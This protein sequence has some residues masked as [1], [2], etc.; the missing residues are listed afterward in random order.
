MIHQYI[1]QEVI[2]L[3]YDKIKGL[4][5]GVGRV[6]LVLPPMNPEKVVGIGWAGGGRRLTQVQRGPA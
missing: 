4:Y 5:A 2:N 1:Y 6:I 3:I